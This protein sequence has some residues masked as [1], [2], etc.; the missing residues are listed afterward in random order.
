M[1]SP[2]LSNVLR[3]EQEVQHWLIEWIARE[4][5][6][7]AI[8]IDVEE[9]LVNYGLSSRQAVVLAGELEDWLGRPMPA[10]LVW[11]YPTIGRMARHLTSA[12]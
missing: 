12:P 8:A 10:S 6:V 11:D 1:S 5:G 3:T 4:A 9:Q 2:A 7:D